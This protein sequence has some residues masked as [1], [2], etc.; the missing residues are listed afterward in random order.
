M[1]LL[2]RNEGQTLFLVQGNA[3]RILDSRQF[4]TADDLHGCR[5]D[6]HQFINSVYSYE[7][8]TR[9]GV[10]HRIARTPGPAEWKR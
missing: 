2:A 3:M 9:S 8:V 1:I 4:V 10:V 5:I 7:D 6:R